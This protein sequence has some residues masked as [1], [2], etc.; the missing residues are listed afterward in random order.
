[1]PRQLTRDE[2]YAFLDSRPGWMAITTIGPDG[3]PHTVPV[4]Y[5]RLDDTIVM[6]GPAGSRRFRNVESNPRVSLMIEQGSERQEL[7]G[8]MIQGDATLHKDPQARLRFMRE[9]ARRRGVPEDQLPTEASPGAAYLE[10]EI[11]KI[12]SWDYSA[13]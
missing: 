9:G 4:G 8:V 10:V 1:M 11:R 5:Y 13:G 7:M 2:V 3:Y 12:V 6:G